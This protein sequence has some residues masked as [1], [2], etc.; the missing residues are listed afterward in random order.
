MVDMWTDLGA[1]LKAVSGLG[2]GGR[3]AAKVRGQDHSQAGSGHF[4]GRAT[5]GK[6]GQFSADAFVTRGSQESGR[7]EA[8]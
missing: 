3:S 6:E 7:G 5:D 2:R 4:G 1:Y 8:C